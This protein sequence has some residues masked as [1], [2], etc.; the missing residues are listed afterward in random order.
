VS[1][2]ASELIELHDVQAKLGLVDPND[3][4]FCRQRLMGPAGEL[5]PPPL[6]GGADL[7][8]QGIPRGPLFAKLLQMVRDAQLD[9]IV[10]DRAAALEFVQTAWQNQSS[11]RP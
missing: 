2:G 5:N 8:A 7:I 6:I 10:R 11:E 1:G 3:V 4:A 9:E